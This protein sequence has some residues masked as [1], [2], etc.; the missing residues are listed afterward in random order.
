MRAH[1]FNV[2]EHTFPVHRD[3]GFCGTGKI[4][5]PVSDYQEALDR[6]RVLHIKSEAK[7]VQLCQPI[8]DLCQIASTKCNFSASNAP[9]YCR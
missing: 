1:I 6:P 3:R 2:D 9:L 8:T 7:T 5:T 4:G